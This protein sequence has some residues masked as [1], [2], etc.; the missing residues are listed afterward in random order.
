MLTNWYKQGLSRQL[1]YSDTM[2]L[3]KSNLQDFFESL[4]ISLAKQFN[5]DTID[6]PL[7]KTED[8]QKM[9]KLGS[10]LQPKFSE[11][12]LIMGFLIR[13]NLVYNF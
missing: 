6:A 4:N 5:L 7:E 8:G 2:S 13:D 12:G 3:M 1:D 11:N 9:L 10:I